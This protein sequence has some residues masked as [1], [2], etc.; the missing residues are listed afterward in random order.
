MSVETA[1]FAELLRALKD[2]SGRSYGA[3]ATRLHVST[4]TLHRYCNG[5]AVPNE[6]APVERLARVCGAS[7]DELV[8]LHRRWILADASRRRESAGPP[9][10]PAAES[11]PSTTA[12]EPEPEPPVVSVAADSPSPPSAERPPA[13][14][15]EEPEERP[16]EE[17]VE[18]PHRRRRTTRIL[19]SAAA[20]AVVAALVPVVVLSGRSGTRAAGPGPSA[21]A[22]A[23]VTAP[24]SAAP[25]PAGPTGPPTE[26]TTT[27]APAAPPA[28][29][30][31]PTPTP[32]AADDAAPFH[33]NVLTDNWGS[34]CGQ[35]LVS[36]Q[37][38][39]TTPAPPTGRRT[40][41]WAA[42]QHAVPG[43]H[44]RLQLTAQGAEDK[45]VVLHAL[46]VQVVSTRPAPKSNAYMMGSGCGGALTPAAFAV[47]LDAT[48]PRSVPVPAMEGNRKGRTS[49]F[50]FRVSSTDPQ[51][52]NVD[53]STAG[54]DVSW[55]L[56]VVWSSGD[57]QG[58]FLVNDHGRPFRTVGLRGTPGY[59]WADDTRGWTRTPTDG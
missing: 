7:A 4:S 27:P 6:Y 38:P 32:P 29:T 45:P 46:Y 41:A 43:G 39:G 48:A 8:E 54:Q 11:T 51:V 57:R 35:W 2:R 5:A 40:D 47:D 13:P 21:S 14:T 10:P 1:N 26:P 30:A 49:D 28:A 34:P 37:P 12:T 25:D 56:E 15:G 9:A 24:V 31:D 20:V 16:V 18:E 50:P 44:L 59:F 17:P 55:Y 22:S 53:A 52:L 58:T 3:L 33:V 42:A 23:S 36:A 19:L